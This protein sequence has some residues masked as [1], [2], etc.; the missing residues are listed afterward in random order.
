VNHVWWPE[1]VPPPPPRRPHY[2]RLVTNIDGE[3]HVVGDTL[4][5]EP[6]ECRA[7]GG[8]LHSEGHVSVCEN[9]DEARWRLET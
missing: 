2:I 3:E 1:Y 7:C 4:C 8:R 5:C 6:E 9:C